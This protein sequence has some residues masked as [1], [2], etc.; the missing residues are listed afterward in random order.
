M[1]FK[2]NLKEFYRFGGSFELIEPTRVDPRRALQGS[3]IS[4]VCVHPIQFECYPFRFTLHYITNFLLIK[5]NLT[6]I[7]LWDGFIKKTFIKRFIKLKFM[8]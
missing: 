7:L 8:K 5:L 2:D 1:I 6:K 3:M 4:L